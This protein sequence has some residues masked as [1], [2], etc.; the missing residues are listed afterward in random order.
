MCNA[1]SSKRWMLPQQ[2]SRPLRVC[3]TCYQQLSGKTSHASRPTT[4]CK[5]LAWWLFTPAVSALSLSPRFNSRPLC[6][7]VCHPSPG[8]F[9]SLFVSSFRPL[10]LFVCDQFQASLSLLSLCHPPSTPGLSVSSF[11]LSVS[12][13][14]NSRPLCLFILFVCVTHLQ[15]QASL[16]LLSLCHPPSTPGLSVS[17]FSLSV[18]LTFNSRPLCLFFVCHN[19]STPG[20][21]VSSF[22]LSVSLTFNSRPLFLFFLFVCVTHLQLQASLSL[23]SLCL[24]HPPITPGLFV[25]SFSLSGDS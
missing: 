25:S 16:S 22:S 19:P 15:L 12:L 2:S 5:Q 7:F 20:L 17:S 9:V 3:L 23:L 4:T 14:F 21:F 18:S 11:S 1:C 10:C 24:C 6:L 13:T 8:L